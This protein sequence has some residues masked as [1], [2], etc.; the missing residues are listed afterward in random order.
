MTHE[1]AARDPSSVEAGTVS[2]QELPNKGPFRKGSPGGA[3]L[4]WLSTTTVLVVL[5]VGGYLYWQNQQQRSSASDATFVVRRGTV[6]ITIGAT[7]VIR[8]YR[9]VKVSPKQMGLIERLY[10]KQ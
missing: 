9:E 7:G 6:D 10:V 3:K 4:Y 5:A 8:P 1:V 2:K